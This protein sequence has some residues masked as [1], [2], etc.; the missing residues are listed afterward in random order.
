MVTAVGGCALSGPA[1][2]G[3][4][5]PP[6]GRCRPGVHGAVQ[7]SSLRSPRSGPPQGRRGPHLR[8]RCAAACAPQEEVPSHPVTSSTATGFGRPPSCSTESVGATASHPQTPAVPA[9]SEPRGL[10]PAPPG[11]AGPAEPADRR[12]RG[13]GGR[14]P[15]RSQR[16]GTGLRLYELGTR[17][18]VWT[19]VAVW[20]DP[21]HGS[22]V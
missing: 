10:F 7:F 14:R 19:G 15:C 6:G 12:P 20:R 4:G 3:P 9:G 5:A 1:L 8:S 22:M 21:A 13:A 11:G 2:P 17:W 18:T 16:G